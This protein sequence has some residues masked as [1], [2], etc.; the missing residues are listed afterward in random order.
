MERCLFNYVSRDFAEQPPPFTAVPVAALLDWPH[1]RQ[2]KL[3]VELTT[4]FQEAFPRMPAAELRD[5]VGDYFCIPPGGLRRHALLLAAE[6]R[7]LVATTLFD[8]GSVV[9]GGQT[10]QGVYIVAR[11][12]APDWQHAGLGRKMAREVLAQ[13][14]PDILLTTCTQSASLHSWIGAVQK[15]RGAEFEVFPRW[16]QETL[17]PLPNALRHLAVGAFHRLYLGVAGGLSAQVERAAA[18]LS[19]SLVRK[20][21]YSERYDT[22]PWQ[23]R[24]QKDPLAEALGAGLGDGILV[25][26]LRRR[27]SAVPHEPVVD[28]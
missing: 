13:W 12:I 2:K 1:A 25:V 3:E 5:W 6:D 14:R 7:R 23:Q 11:A 17:Q 9:Y 8:H 21:L 27:L 16:E 19:P 20:G 15:A 10:L 26:V 4:L 22:Y 28:P 24:R 18:S